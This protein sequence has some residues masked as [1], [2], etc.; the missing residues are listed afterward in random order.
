MTAQ[1]VMWII[2]SAEMFKQK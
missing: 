2:I 1:S